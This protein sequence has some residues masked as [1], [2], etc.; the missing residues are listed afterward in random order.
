LE[1]N[2]AKIKRGLLKK[3]MKSKFVI[4]LGNY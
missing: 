2:T 3:E 4:L 1:I